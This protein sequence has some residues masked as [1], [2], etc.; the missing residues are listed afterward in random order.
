MQDLDPY[1]KPIQDFT[2]GLYELYGNLRAVAPVWRSPRT[3]YWLVSGYE[4]VTALLKEP[5]L[6]SDLYKFFPAEKTVA[7]T[8]LRTSQENWMS[9]QDEPRHSHLRR[10]FLELCSPA[11]VNLL[12]S[13]ILERAEILSAP[14]RVKGEMEFVGD[15]VVPLVISLLAH[16][17]GV[18]QERMQDFNYAAQRTAGH[19]PPDADG[20]S[21]GFKA[22]AILLDVFASKL[23][24]DHKI[25]QE[26][27]VQLSTREQV[28]NLC[29]LVFA[30]FETLVNFLPNA[31]LEILKHPEQREYFCAAS[32]GG[33]EAAIDE[34]LRYCGS[35]LD[36]PRV[37]Q[38]DFELEALPGF[39]FKRGDYMLLMLAAANR[40]PLQFSEP[41]KLDLTRANARHLALGSGAHYCIGSHL[42]KLLSRLLLGYMLESFPNLSFDSERVKY[43]PSYGL[44]GLF[45]LYLRA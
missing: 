20:N 34:L 6:S 23:S 12:E 41:D 19:L 27:A 3:G 4:A 15:L 26:G 22:A 40:D 45:Y 36:I 10:D 31:L 18:D 39:V 8:A 2:A 1:G 16:W 9:M 44:R 43:I 13:Y 7:S 42:S 14:L 37:V 21:P 24:S 35:V 33:R 38:Q 11:R 5:G 32:P 17:L 28:D 30:A 29:L 25:T